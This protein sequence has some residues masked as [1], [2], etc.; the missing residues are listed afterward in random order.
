MDYSPLGSSV[1]GILQ[2]RI[3]EWVAIPF[4]RALI[5]DVE[6]FFMCLLAICMTCLEKGLF[7]YFPHFFIGLFVFSV[8]EL[9]ELLA[10]FGNLSFVSYFICYC[11]L[12]F[13][14][15]S[16]HLAL[17]SFAVQKLLSLIRSHFFISIFFSFILG[18]GLL[19]ILLCF[20]SLS[21]LLMFS[22]K[23][24]IVPGLSFRA[25]INFEFSLSMVLG[26]V[27]ISFFYM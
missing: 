19:M 14:G 13:S 11:I 10:Y 21:V 16:I 5:S 18:D 20:M 6:Y 1:H 3:L 9:Y 27:L 15:L 25:L 8:R 24:S 22:S 4:S 2:A 23:S 12:P 7:K 26:S 17:V